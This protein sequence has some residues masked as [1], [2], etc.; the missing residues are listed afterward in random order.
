MAVCRV[1][2]VGEDFPRPSNTWRA[3]TMKGKSAGMGVRRVRSEAAME[4]RYPVA[5]SELVLAAGAGPGRCKH[6]IIC[7]RG[8]GLPCVSYTR[9]ACACCGPLWA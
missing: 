9:T 8:L 4:T 6:W 5:L 1:R 2:P 3:G 7:L